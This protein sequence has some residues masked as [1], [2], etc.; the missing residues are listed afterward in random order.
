MTRARL[1][2]VFWA[3]SQLVHADPTGGI[4]GTI[5]DP[6]GAAA[7]GAKITVTA[8]ATGLSREVFSAGDGGY[9]FPLLPVGLYTVA[10]EA[11]GFRRFEQKGV[12]VRADVTVS[13][14]VTLQLGNV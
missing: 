3:F 6:S 12:E 4:A 9:V 14:P 13:V 2:L 11:A 5:L 10:V 8:S 1:L 7:A